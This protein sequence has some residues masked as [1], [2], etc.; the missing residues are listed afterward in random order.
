MQG[1]FAALAADPGDGFVAETRDE[2]VALRLVAV[3]P[4]AF[5][6]F[7]A[8]EQR[9]FRL[10]EPAALFEQPER[11]RARLPVFAGVPFAG[12]DAPPGVF[13]AVVGLRGETADRF[14]AEAHPQALDEPRPVFLLRGSVAE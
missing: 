9:E 14:G 8:A 3:P 1:P 10:G 11:P 12:L 5:D 4:A 7:R 6:A 13:R 2:V